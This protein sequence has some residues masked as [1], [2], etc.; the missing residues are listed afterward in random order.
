MLSYLCLFFLHILTQHRAVQRIAV[1]HQPN[2]H[3]EMLY[4]QYQALCTSALSA[5]DYPAQPE[6]DLLNNFIILEYSIKMML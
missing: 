3:T 5:S 4:G 6:G 1:L 2:I